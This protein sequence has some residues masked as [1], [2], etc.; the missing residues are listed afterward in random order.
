MVFTPGLQEGQPD[1]FAAEPQQDQQKGNN[2]FCHQ[3]NG[4]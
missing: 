2:P 3:L 4:S 1:A